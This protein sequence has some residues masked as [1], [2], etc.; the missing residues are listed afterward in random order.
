MPPIT[1]PAVILRS[2]EYGDYDL[3]V[4]FFTFEQGKVATLAKNARKS[5]KRFGGA[6]ELF[7]LVEIVYAHGKKAGR[8]PILSE[9]NLRRHFSNIRMD[10]TK[11]ALASLWAETIYSWA[12]EEQEQQGLFSL[13]IHSLENLDKDS[14]KGD[15]INL[16]FIIRFLGMA[17]LSPNLNQCVACSRPLEDWG[18]GRICFDHA[19]GGIVCPECDTCKLP[20]PSLSVGTVKQLL[21]LSRGDLDMAGRMKLSGEATARGMELMES[22]LAYH[23]GREPKSLR[24]LRNLRRQGF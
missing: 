23:L 18:K 20:G 5:F 22:F 21:W 1:T 9:S 24:F 11:T 16:L 17:G 12:E 2:I 13:L 4:T 14:A 6:L 19:R 7:S 10:I 3:I 8:L 15:K